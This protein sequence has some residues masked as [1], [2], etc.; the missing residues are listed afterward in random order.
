MSE[1]VFNSF[2]RGTRHR[3]RIAQRRH[4]NLPADAEVVR[5]LTYLQRLQ[6]MKD[7]T[8]LERRITER[9]NRRTWDSLVNYLLTLEAR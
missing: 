5:L 9:N 8:P 2:R 4:D 3:V 7:R 1:P 6:R